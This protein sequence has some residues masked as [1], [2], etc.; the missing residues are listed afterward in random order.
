MANKRENNDGSKEF[1]KP[2]LTNLGSQIPPKRRKCEE[3]R[4]QAGTNDGSKASKLTG[5]FTKPILNNLVCQIPPKR[6]KCEEG[7]VGLNQ[8]MRVPTN[9]IHPNL[10]HIVGAPTSL[11]AI[12]QVT[13]SA[14]AHSLPV[15]KANN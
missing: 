1:T 11:P 9:Q 12:I 4:L 7:R 15:S 6:R 3:G 14:D 10:F 5:E 13:R 2:I 8:F